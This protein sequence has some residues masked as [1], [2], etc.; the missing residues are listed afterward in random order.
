MSETNTTP[1]VVTSDKYALNWR[2]VLKAFLVATLSTPVSVVLTSIQAGNLAIDWKAMGI[3]ALG[4]AASYLLKNFI[5]PSLTQAPTNP[6]S[7]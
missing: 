5:T 3:L 2:D 6:A 1:P 4:S 7:K